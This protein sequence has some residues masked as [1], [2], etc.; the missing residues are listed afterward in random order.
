MRPTRERLG[1]NGFSL[2]ELLIFLTIGTLVVGA[3]YQVVRFQQRVYRSQRATI[4]RHDALRLASSVLASD[5][6]EASGREGDFVALGPDSIV[7]RSPVGFGV[8]CDTDNSDKRVGLF[9]AAGRFS[10]S[11]GDSLLI[12][13]PNGWM[14]KEIQSVNPTGTASLKCPYAT[15]P[16]LDLTLRVG[17]DVDGVPVG[18]PVRAF[19]VYTYHL[20]QDRESWWLARSDA[21]SS[22]GDILDILVGP[23]SNDGTGLAFAYSDENDQATTDPT[24]VARVDLSL[25]AVSR[26][27]AER[28]TLTTSV[29][30]RNQ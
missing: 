6:M 26:G 13:H 11:A 14:V 7:I 12:Y 28:D 20:K 8:V 4:E 25:V 18:A 3:L 5:I 19:H 30:P 17:G 1:R 15:G 29:R 22:D 10:A 24:Q 21:T 27:Y 9:D 2:V 23:F 16:A